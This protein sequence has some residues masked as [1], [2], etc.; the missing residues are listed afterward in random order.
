MKTVKIILMASMLVFLPVAIFCQHQT[1][2]ISFDFFGDSITLTAPLPA[3]TSSKP[4]FS[5]EQVNNYFADILTADYQPL[6]DA[7]LQYRKQYKLDDWLYYQLIRRTVQQVSPKQEN[8]ERYTVYKWFL[9]V[10]SGYGA[11]LKISRTKLLFYVQTDEQIF[12]LPYY[13]KNG[14]QYVCLNYHDYKPIDFITERFKELSMLQEEVKKSFTYKVQQLPH[15]NSADYIEK[16]IQFNYYNQEYHFKVKLNPQ[17]KTIFANYP[18]VDYASYFNIPV[19]NE[20]YQSLIPLIKDNIRGM[21]V[22]AGVDFLMRFTRYAFLF[23]P[24]SKVFG[25]ER[26]L[27]PEQTLLYDQSDCEDRSALFFFL[28]KEIYNL[29]MIVLSFPKHITVAVKF[30]KAVGKSI[31]YNNANYTVCEPTPQGLL[32]LPIGQLPPAVQNERYE[33]VYSYNPKK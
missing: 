10:K 20:T 5:E 3:N 2:L 9:L 14:Q 11:T 12:E 27:T 21:K 1:K 7:L 22:K 17:I 24:D 4:P 25:Q 8:Y 32:D 15:F 13:E 28:V 16:D 29:P 23:E 26:R 30:D 6:V 19:S 33:V 31:R 18:V